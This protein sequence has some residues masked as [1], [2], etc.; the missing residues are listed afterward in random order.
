MRTRQ[1]KRKNDIHALAEMYGVGWV[2]LEDELEELDPE[3]GLLEEEDDDGLLE[4]EEDAGLAEEEEE[5][6][7]GLAAEDEEG[8]DEDDEARGSDGIL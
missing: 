3:D 4:E 1:T 2:G 7:E 5:E 8:L 6:E